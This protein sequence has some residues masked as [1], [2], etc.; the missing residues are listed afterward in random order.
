ME[1]FELGSHR[2]D[3][4]AGVKPIPSARCRREL[5]QKIKV[6]ARLKVEKRNAPSRNGSAPMKALTQTTLKIIAIGCFDGV[7]QKHCGKC[8]L[9]F[10]VNAPA[11]LVVQHMPEKFTRAFA[12]R[13]NGICAI[14]VRE[15]K[16]GDTLRQ[17]LGADRSRKQAHAADAK[18]ARFYSVVIKDG[19]RVHH[20]RPAVDGN[21]Q[22]CS[23][24]RGRKNAI[25]VVF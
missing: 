10:P 21:I 16:S 24:L 3:V 2:S 18:T 7:E 6:A 20:Q 22:I 14:E 1:G 5:I 13:L 19:P 4:Q 23:P 12:D 8:S 11:A 15:A 17:G 25:G 9:A